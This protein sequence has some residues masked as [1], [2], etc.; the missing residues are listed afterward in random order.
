[1]AKSNSPHVKFIKRPLADFR[2]TVDLVDMKK[3]IIKSADWYQAMVENTQN[4]VWVSDKNVKVIYANPKLCKLLGYSYEDIVGKIEYKFWAKGSANKVKKALISD[5]NK[6]VTSSYEAELISKKGEKIP[7]LA[8]GTP[9]PDGGTVGI[10]TDLRELKK[11][12]EE[13]LKSE[14]RFKTLA[15][16]LPQVVFETDA[17]GNLIF[18]NERSYAISGY[19]KKEFEKG[20]NAIQMITPDLR[21]YAVANIERILRTRKF[22]VTEYVFLR[23]DGSTFPC[24]IHS[25]PVIKNGKS[26]GTRGILIDI[27][28]H[29]RAEKALSDSE[30]KYRAIFENTGTATI[31]IEEDMTISLANS[32]FVKM[33]GIP[34]NKIEGNMKFPEFF[35]KE[36][37]GKMI[38]YHNLRRSKK[39]GAPRNYEARLVNK[40]GGTRN[41][42]LTVALV[43]GTKQSVASLLDITKRKRMEKTVRESEELYRSMVD[44]SMVGICMLKETSISFSNRK[45]AN[46]FGYKTADE[47]MGKDIQKFLTIKS[48][49]EAKAKTVARQE[50][51]R[52]PELGEYTGIKKNG[53][54]IH[55]QTYSKQ[56]KVHSEI[57]SQVFVMD[58][59]EKKIVE[60]KLKERVK[61]MN[62]LF[63]VHSHIQ[64]IKPVSTVLMN[65]SRDITHAFQ[66]MEVAVAKIV[67]DDKVYPS[68][69]AKAKSKFV[70]SLQTPIVIDGQKRGC[71]H[72]GYTKKL[73]EMKSR[74]FWSEERKLVNNVAIILSKHIFSREF[75][76]RHKKIVT[77]SVTGIY[78]ARNGILKYVN[79]RF[80]TMFKCTKEDALGKSISKFVK[81]FDCCQKMK[82]IPNAPNLKMEDIGVRKDNTF[83]SVDI[84]LQRIDYHGKEAVLGRIHDVT[85]IKKAEEN[86]KTFNAELK[87]QVDEKTKHLEKA[88][89][90]LQSLNDLKDE[91][92]AVT[93][94]ELRSPLTSVRGYLSFLVERESLEGLPPA[95][96]QYLLRAYNN[97]ESLNYLVNNILDVSRLDLGRFVLQTRPCNIVTLTKNVIE[98]L[99]FQSNEKKIKINFS[100]LSQSK[101]LELELDS[102]RISQVLRNLVDNAIK[103]S[104]IGKKISIKIKSNKNYAVI[105]ITDQGVGIPKSKLDEI[106][107]KFFQVKNVDSRY[108]GGAGLGLFISKRIIEL[109]GGTIEVSSQKKKGTMFK[110]SLP[111]KKK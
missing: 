76:E 34:A 85:L 70:Y 38:E 18:V 1:M 51:K 10:L 19:S 79:P 21:K 2:K 104:K 15:N 39:G 108:K 31:I 84:S 32:E 73:P 106:F 55:I 50:G 60:R 111:L 86:L 94:H 80:C 89:K 27:S 105:Q 61:E 22:S 65:V 14:E 91:F 92:I 35:Y 69:K 47:I 93:S 101:N 52:V 8:L 58:I 71:I 29:K 7:V 40:K 68:S 33:S 64:M 96:Q 62:V 24:V 87:K 66:F 95:I 44:Q 37:A 45:L 98:S 20:L 28:D 5:R 57:Y 83:I 12:D 75:L 54:K 74:P 17:K 4:G 78:I 90:R 3:K 49:K 25:N 77:K 97:A 36:D 6:G 99:S 16:T 9:L 109:H 110:I 56:I 46:M 53:K 42:Y 82:S 26:V 63:R 103:F 67:F 81:G 102:I 100:N 43:P 13:L 88:N 30:H 41:I 107:N 72:V 11:K 59:T 23:K 48:N